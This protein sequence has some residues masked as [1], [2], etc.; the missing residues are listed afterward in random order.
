MKLVQSVRR[1]VGVLTVPAAV[2]LASGMV[3][4]ASQAAFS[5]TTRNS[6]DSW[7][8]G[9]VVLA[10]DDAGSARFQATNLRPGATET[11]CITVTSS[12]SLAG[13]VR[14]FAINAVTSP[15]GLEQHILMT[16]D[17]GTGGSFGSCTGFTAA[18]TDVTATSLATIASTHTDFATGLGT[19][20]P[21]GTP[22][23][24]RTYRF[25][26]AFDTTGMTQTQV[27]ALQ[28][29]H[30]GIDFEWEIQNT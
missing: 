21:T 23:E 14:L 24:S 29:A 22:P 17:E 4:Q 11:R 13:Q 28:G 30:T 25:T 2:L 12:A 19:W 6:G 20:S 10:D 27:D 1:T 8:T 3:W 9:T 15:S 5:D 26:W 16:V 18:A 7:A